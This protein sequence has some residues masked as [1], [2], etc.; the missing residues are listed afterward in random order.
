MTADPAL[1]IR[2]LRPTDEP[3]VRDG[4]ERAFGVRRS[5]EEW[6][7]KF[8]PRPHG[9]AIEVAFDARG[10]LVAHYA[11]LPVEMQRQERHFLAG[12][13][14]DVFTRRKL[15]LFRRRGPLTRTIESLVARCCGPGRLELLYG[16]P[17]LRALELGRATGVY[18]AEAA[19]PRL[20]APL[21][22]VAPPS[23]LARRLVQRGFDAS[24]LDALWS[25][26]ALRYPLAAVRD[27]AWYRRRF[28]DRPGVAYEQLGVRRR[29]RPAAWAVVRAEPERLRWADLVWDGESA[30]D[31]ELW[32][33]G[34]DE[35]AGVLRD[36]G[37]RAE[38]H[39]ELRLAAR[40]F[41]ADLEHQEL[42]R[43]LYLTLAD[44]DLV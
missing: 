15:G 11:A 3:A 21:A 40:S 9:R 39:P 31:L 1:E 2:A 10:E 28:L 25:A 27:A 30:A 37:W 24:G 5:L 8:D 23:R 34:D 26:A 44:S 29:G 22:P 16:F 33:S 13:I 6:R 43:R 17:S 42:V 7:W 14:V 32:L 12:Q 19:V 20:Q 4:F 18:P 35:A 38:P 41:V 36:L